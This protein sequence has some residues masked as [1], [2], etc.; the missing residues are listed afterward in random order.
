MRYVPIMRF[1][2]ILF[3]I[4]LAGFGQQSPFGSQ[5]IRDNAHANEVMTQLVAN[6]P[7]RGAA[8]PNLKL[9]LSN[10]AGEI[11]LADLWKEKP[12]VLIFGSLTCDVSCEFS[13]EIL[14]VYQKFRDRANFAYIYIREAHPK[15]GW[16]VAPKYSVIDDPKTSAERSAAAGRFAAL[17]RYPFPI[18]V[19][20]IE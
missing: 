1:L 14:A 20:T 18:L 6:S 2:L 17:T 13:K 11:A 9:A 15:D 10:G 12:L 3:V 19:D 16:I 5:T 4:P 8:A 7:A